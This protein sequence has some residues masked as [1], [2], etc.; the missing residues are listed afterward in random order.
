MKLSTTKDENSETFGIF[1]EKEMSPILLKVLKKNK[2]ERTSCIVSL[3][4][5]V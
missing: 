2:M 3:N 5:T 1:L 4:L